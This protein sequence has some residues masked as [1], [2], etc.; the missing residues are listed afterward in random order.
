MFQTN[1]QIDKYLIDGCLRCKY[2]A[3]PQCKVHR[4]KA[5]LLLLREI[6]LSSGLMEELKWG[7]PV[8][9][10]NGKNVLS[11]SALK[12]AAVLSFFKGALMKNE[13]SILE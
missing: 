7:V 2:G 11:F 12:D 6:A 13:E 9:T 10:L 4:W 1:P 5:E 3:T 8:Y